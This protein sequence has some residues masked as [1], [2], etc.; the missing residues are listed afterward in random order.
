VSETGAL[1]V[2]GAGRVGTAIARAAVDAGYSVAIAGSGAVERIRLITEILVPGATAMSA[3]DAVATAELVVLAVPLHKF[4]TVDPASLAGKIVIDV[5]NYWEP[6]DGHQ[7]DFEDGLLGSSE[8]VQE[9]LTRSRV[10]KTLNHTGYHEIEEDRRQAG[11]ADRRAVGVAGDDRSAVHTV[12]DFVD[13]IGFDAV[14]LDS[15]A[16]GRILQ[17]GGPIF[18]VRTTREEFLR[19]LEPTPSR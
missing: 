18:G 7:A 1:A 11:A 4:H 12:M 8:I 19:H 9:R 2:L 14:E 17:P 3:E 13:R 16:R 15:L 10:V 6:I 5:M